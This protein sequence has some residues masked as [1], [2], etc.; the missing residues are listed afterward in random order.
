LSQ[1]VDMPLNSPETPNTVAHTLDHPTRSAD[2]LG[3]QQAV[4]QAHYY[5]QLATLS[6]QAVDL[7]DPQELLLRAPSLAALAMGCESAML[8]LLEPNH[9]EL[10]VVSA[11]GPTGG[12]S[13]GY[14]MPVRADSAA[15]FVVVQRAVVVIPDW[16]S[17]HR[18]AVPLNLIEY[19]LKSGLGVPL[20]DQGHVVGV[21]AMGSIQLNHF[22]PDEVR[23]LQ[24]VASVLATSL[25][26]AQMESQLRQAHKME[27]VGQL[28]GG[29]A[30][31]FNN[32]LTV[33]QGNLQ[34]VQEHLQARHD[35]HGLELLQA[36]DRASRRAAE[37]TG[38][39]LAFSRRQVLSPSRVDLNEL[40][41]SLIELL[42]RTLGENISVTLE[43]KPQCPPCLADKV[44]LESALLNIAINARDAMPDGGQLSFV[45]SAFHGPC[46]QL[47]G[48]KLGHITDGASS[49]AC[50]GVTDTGVGMSKAVLDRAFEPFFTTK[51]VGR[52]TGLGLSSVYG[53]VSQSHGSISLDSQPGRGTTVT[54]LLPTFG[55]LACTVAPRAAVKVLSEGLRVLLVEDDA[56]VRAVAQRFLESLKCKVSPYATAESAWHEL[57]EGPPF[58]L[59]MTDIELGPGM[60]GTEF[61]RRATALRPQLPV[62]LSSG[63]SDYLTDERR[64]EPGRWRLLKKP[65]SK[66]E[67]TA[68]VAAAVSNG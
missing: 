53:F 42:R 43:V 57:M 4:R 48:A 11:H 64:E 14:R 12:R 5:E 3:V 51:D 23:F 25:Q 28:T 20:F 56:E 61:A 6:Q 38:Q 54:M 39:L 13:E 26:R 60:K 33:I 8:C 22:G 2:S 19:G 30:H 50:I 31:D 32:L 9:L 44:Q 34:M 66:E 47:A 36:V 27:S 24:A 10:R 21:L 63:F 7:T 15:G 1:E 17:E 68:A 52:G 29:I 46:G 41:P 62:L 40:L 35:K 49:W 59:L 16:S 58:D 55:G 65:F 18:F 37:L 67:L 45:C